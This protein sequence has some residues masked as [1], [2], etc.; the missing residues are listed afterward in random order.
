MGWPVFGWR[1]E[2]RLED[3]EQSSLGKNPVDVPM[4]MD[5]K[6]IEFMLMTTKEHPTKR[7][8]STSRWT[9]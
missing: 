5:A 4:E 7:R 3:G 8:L 6:C 9:R 2:A 1:E